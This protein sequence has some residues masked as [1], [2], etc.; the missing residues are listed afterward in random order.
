MG[1]NETSI[2][3]MNTN[4]RSV[5][6]WGE[7]IW[8]LFPDGPR[9]G[10]CAAN[11]AYHVSRL[12]SPARLVSRVG[13]DEL[14]RGAV[15]FLRGAGVDTSLVQVDPRA[16][17]GVVR[18]GI[19]AGEPQFSIVTEAAWDRIDIGADVRG[20]LAEAKVLYFGTLAQRTPLGATTLRAAVAAC[21]RD[22]VR[23]CDLNVR[24]PFVTPEAMDFSVRTADVIKLNEREAEFI[25]KSF[26]CNDV[27]DWLF[28]QPQLRLVALTRGSKGS[29]LVTRTRRVETDAVR[30][31]S[32][33]AD[34]VGAGDAFA[35]VLSHHA[36]MMDDLERLG[37]L[38][39]RYAGFVASQ[40]GAMPF[41]PDD[42]VRSAQ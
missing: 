12:G 28:E 41:V 4:R 24:P 9:L 26:G 38:A 15:E 35:A 31:E 36:A 14:G 19:A 11:V 8:D 10:G 18:I 5:I 34:A 13:N 2:A 6:C 33:D 40:R 16:P 30:Y 32:A 25:S 42:V 22:C 21:A 1:A 37:V 17:T 20:A 39:N 7:L 3:G 23:V 27:I 29:V